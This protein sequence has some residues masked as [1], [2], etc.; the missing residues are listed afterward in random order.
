VAVL[1]AGVAAGA[2]IGASIAL[3][4]PLRP[5]EPISTRKTATPLRDLRVGAIKVSEAEEELLEEQLSRGR[6]FLGGDIA[7]EEKFVIV[8]GAGG[9]GSH[10]AHMLARSGLRRLRIIDFD[11]V[12]LSSLNRHAVATRAD[13]GLPKVLAIK[14]FVKEVVP[15]C[16]VDAVCKMFTA[17]AASDLLGGSPDYVMDCIDDTDTKLDL[18]E[19]CLRMKLRLLS[20]MAAGAKVDPTRLHLCELQNVARDPIASKIRYD[21]RKRAKAKGIPDSALERV[22]VI[23]SSEEPTAKLLPLDDEVKDEAPESLGAVANFRVRIIPVL[24]PIPALFGMSMAIRAITNL[25]GRTFD[26]NPAPTL[27]ARLA[28]K[29]YAK[30]RTYVTSLQKKMQQSA[31]PDEAEDAEWK[32]WSLDQIDDADIELICTQSGL[33]CPVSGHKLGDGAKFQMAP[34]RYDRPIQAHNLVFVSPKG[35]AML[36]DLSLKRTVPNPADLRM[37]PSDFYLALRILA[38]QWD[39]RVKMRAQENEAAFMKGCKRALAHMNK[40]HAEDNLTLVK[41]FTEKPRSSSATMTEIDRFRMTFSVEGQS[42]R[43]F[44]SSKLVEPKELRE[45]IVKLTLRAREIIAGN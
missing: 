4:R 35:A 16:A 41:A 8:V 9:V 11:N 37:V 36:E 3:Q 33:R 6:S 30:L 22:E 28:N 45:T 29:L 25:A 44:F 18:I 5:L 34:W 31:P 19:A 17:D 10:C 38:S 43:V 13:V 40:D 26:P 39:V 32:S 15:H 24:G 23:Y 20:S 42:V 1:L 12:T 2:A 7:W 27:R 21:M 14:N